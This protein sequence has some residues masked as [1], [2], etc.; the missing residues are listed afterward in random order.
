MKLK[1]PTAAES[2]RPCFVE[3]QSV[4]PISKPCCI[5]CSNSQN[6]FAFQKF[7]G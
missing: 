1:V 2:T 7:Y 6:T 4:N 3:S 5:S